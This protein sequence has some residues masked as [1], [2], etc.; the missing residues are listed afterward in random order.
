M[1]P[2]FRVGQEYQLATL[3]LCL[4][5]SCANGGQQISVLGI[6]SLVRYFRYVKELKGTIEFLKISSS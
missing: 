2:D 3:V 6:N 1:F 4:I 5:L